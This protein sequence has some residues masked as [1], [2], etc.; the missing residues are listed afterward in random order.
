MTK[1]STLIERPRQKRHRHG[2]TLL[3]VLV[4]IALVLLIILGVNQVFALT[5]RAVGAGNAMSDGIR[6]NRSAQAVF[7]YD[8]TNAEIDRAPFFLINSEVI[9]AFRNRE[10]QLAD[11]D[12]SPTSTTPA[13]ADNAIR[14]LDRDLD[15]DET[16]AADNT[17]RAFLTQ[18]THRADMLRFFSRF[19]GRRQTGSGTSF[20]TWV[21]SGEHYIVYGHLRQPN[22]ASLATEREGR[23]P[24]MGA[25]STA[26][27]PA[28]NQNN[29]YATQWILG[30]NAFLLKEPTLPSGTIQDV[31]TGQAVPYY[32]RAAS[33]T[34]GN[35]S[36]FSLGSEA[37]PGEEV[38]WGHHDLMGVT[39]QAFRNQ[40][41]DALTL[42][43]PPPLPAAGPQ[44]H[45]KMNSSDTNYGVN[46]R[47]VGFPT[48]TRP[49][50][51]KG[52]SR[53]VPCFVPACTQFVVEYAGDFL[54]QDR[55]P[56][57][58]TYGVTQTVAN[59]S[60]GGTDGEIDFDVVTVAGQKRRKIRWYGF[61]RDT[62]DLAN[63]AIGG[64]GF[65]RGA[66]GDVVPL[67]DHAGANLPFERI[68]PRN[69]VSPLTF[70]YGL[71]NSVP[72][73]AQYRAAWAADTSAYPRPR[74]IRL[75]MA[76]DDPAARISREQYFEY[77]IELP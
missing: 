22:N 18:R 31:R 40:Y 68:L 73:A 52:V 77:V 33:A 5:S 59:G 41:M 66:D 67:A 26:E 43:V 74:M 72:L 58:A 1:I 10:D 20:N 57:S 21:S 11:R 38:N 65:I 8:L 45:G 36:P 15:G 75:V 71:V 55:N 54:A 51:T 3:E 53:T 70:D 63:S 16:D 24:G 27:T 62:Y 44:W 25:L 37:E 14:T 4:S 42:G 34:P 61:P 47:F 69:A 49:L 29:F 48:P 12:Y 32:R 39:M 23:E 50:T 30:R 13:T 2:F 56:G 64:D 28:T 19:Q 35:Y 76:V 17:P 9:S 7:Y 60:G 6:S 46:F